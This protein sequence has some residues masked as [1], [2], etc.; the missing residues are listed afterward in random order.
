[1]VTSL[2][3]NPLSSHTSHI[4]ESAIRSRYTMI[5]EKIPVSANQYLTTIQVVLEQKQRAKAEMQDHSVN[6]EIYFFQGRLLISAG[7]HFS[8]VSWKG[9]EGNSVGFQSSAAPVKCARQMSLEP[10]G[11]R[12]SQ[13]LLDQ[14]ISRLSREKN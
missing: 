3:Q 6:I 5:R 11:W 2:E 13:Q 14:S 7:H 8:G 9:K 4:G 10:A 12:S 1:M